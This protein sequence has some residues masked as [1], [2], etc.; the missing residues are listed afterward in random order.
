MSYAIEGPLFYRVEF[1]I[2][3]KAD[4]FHR[5]L[6]DVHLAHIPRV[7]SA[8]AAIRETRKV[9]EMM[10]KEA[11]ETDPRG[12]GFG[13]AS[14]IEPATIHVRLVEQITEADYRDGML[15]EL[16]KVAGSNGAPRI[17]R[18]QSERSLRL[19]TPEE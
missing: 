2:V 8:E 12:S 11:T 9:V 4:P 18:L 5:G 17:A 15:E 1:Q 3:A 19:L 7:K 16:N 6:P 14:V 13:G 10:T